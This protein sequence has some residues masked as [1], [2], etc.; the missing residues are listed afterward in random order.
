MKRI[1]SMH[2]EYICLKKAKIYA[3][4][5]KRDYCVNRAEIVRAPVIANPVLMN[6]VPR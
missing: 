3:D 5:V 6:V 2:V 1:G 4:Q